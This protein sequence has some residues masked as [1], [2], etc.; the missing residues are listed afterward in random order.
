MRRSRHIDLMKPWCVVNETVAR[1]KLP[2]HVR[3]GARERE[4][5]AFSP[6]GATPNEGRTLLASLVDR[7]PSVSGALRM[8]TAD[9]FE[10]LKAKQMELEK[11]R[12]AIAEL[13]SLEES[14]V[15]FSAHP[16]TTT[17]TL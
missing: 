3:Q 6:S 14:A 11:M 10:R 7:R 8:D 16:T 9:V 1:G 2:S 5:R 12:R 15:R 4:R 17:H 13:Q